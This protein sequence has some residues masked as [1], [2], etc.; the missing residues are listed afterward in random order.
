MAQHSKASVTVEELT[1]K[2]PA[3]L[4]Q[5]KTLDFVEDI[6]HLSRS[7]SQ[8]NLFRSGSVTAVG[9]GRKTGRTVIKSIRS[10]E[11]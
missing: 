1:M 7:V 10:R 6:M 9:F 3:R 5:K 4:D 11:P 8:R 2:S